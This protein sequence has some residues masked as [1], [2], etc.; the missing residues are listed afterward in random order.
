GDPGGGTSDASNIVAT[1]NPDGSAD[2]TWTNNTSPG[3]QAWIPIQY[4]D[5]DGNWQTIDTVPP[6]TTSYHINPP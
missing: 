3:D 4:K 1:M 5:R 2:V 6:G